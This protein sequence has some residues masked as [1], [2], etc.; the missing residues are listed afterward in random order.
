[1]LAKVH[2]AQVSGLK[3]DIIDVEVDI[4]RGLK[5]FSI[6]GLPDKSVD[7]AKDRI[8]AAIKNSGFSPPQKGNMKTIVSLAPADLKKEGPV[9]D[10]AIALAHLLATKEVRFDPKNKLFVGELGL[11]GTLRSVKGILLIAQ[12]ALKHGY[13]ELYVPVENAAEAALIPGISVY[14]VHTLKELCAHLSP[15]RAL[16]GPTAES[17]DRPPIQLTATPRTHV[18]VMEN[19]SAIDFADVRGQETAKRGL[20]I[21]AAGRHNIAMSGPPGTGKTMLAKAFVGI[22]PALP[23]IEMLEATGIHSA[24]GILTTGEFVTHPPLRAPHHTSSYVALV[25][26]GAN[27]RPGEIT[28]SHHGVLFLDEFPEFERRVIEALRQPL[29]DRVVHVARAKGTHAFPANFI[30]VATMNP[31]PCGNRGSTSLTTSGHR[32]ECICSQ[33]ALQ[34]YQR[35]ISGPIIDRIDLWVEVPQV[36]Y[37][38]LGPAKTLAQSSK[39]IRTQ[40]A[41]ARMIQKERFENS[42]FKTNSEMGVRDLEKFAVL[43]DICRK[44]L[45]E[46]AKRLDLSARGYHRVIKLAR[47]IADLAGVNQIAEPHLLEALQYRPKALY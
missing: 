22:L 38:K 44:V 43:S 47:T 12:K 42:K 9:F 23:F 13:K 1:M 35:R 34:K 16:R 37:E 7:E 11:D 45:N 17:A 2:S 5:S 3:P 25:G 28:L 30:L 40:I 4:S 8:S 29:E 26:G 15:E 19:Q 32:K 33:V 46:S 31:C 21:A 27:P 41:R 20:I 18:K 39:D 10:L 36:D 6:V 14:G 24:A